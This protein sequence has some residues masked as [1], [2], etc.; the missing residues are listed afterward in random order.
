MANAS[1]LISFI[2][3]PLFSM[4]HFCKEATINFPDRISLYS[5]PDYDL[6]Y[7]TLT[8]FNAKILERIGPFAVNT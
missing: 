1:V 2:E 8:Q 3:S 5:S 4:H 7:K 6:T